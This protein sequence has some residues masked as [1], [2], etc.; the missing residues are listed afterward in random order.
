[1]RGR[2]LAV[3]ASAAALAAVA[4]A[5]LA[6]PD[7]QLERAV[8]ALSRDP[9]LKVRTQAALVIGQR[10]ARDGVAALARALLEDRAPAVRVAAAAALAR[11]GSAVGQEGTVALHDAADRDPD[12]AVRAGAARALEDL[13]RGAHAVILED[14]GGSAG[15]DRARAALRSALATQLQRRG[16]ALVGS[17][18]AAGFRLKPAVL[19]VD[20]HHGGGA[21]RVEVRAS[22]IAVD[23]RGRI[24]AMVEGGARARSPGAPPSSAGPMTAKALEAAASSICEDLASRLLV[25]KQ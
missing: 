8:Q 3:V 16:F 20:V 4:L 10:G 23:G 15:D 11:I 21:V 1:M 19:L 18:A 13:R 14:V 5:A 9:S 24:A 7:A 25:A 6:G 17:D 2:R 12:P 22:V